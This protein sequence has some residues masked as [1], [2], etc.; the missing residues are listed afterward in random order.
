MFDY[1]LLCTAIGSQDPV[2]LE[3]TPLETEITIDNRSKRMYHLLYLI[4]III[5][6]QHLINF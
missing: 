4:I 6:M 1:T 3:D 2:S 5:A